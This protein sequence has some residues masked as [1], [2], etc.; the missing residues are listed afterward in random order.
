MWI[1]MEQVHGGDLQSYLQKNVVSEADMVE[2]MR[3]LI[4]GIGY[5]HECG[6]IHRDLKPENILIETN[7]PDSFTIKIT[8]F[9]LSKLGSPAELIFDCCGTPAYVAPEVLHK[10]G[11]K[12]QVDLWACGIILYSMIS[13]TFP[14]QSNDRKQTFLQIKQKEPDFSN[15]AFQEEVSPACIDFIKRLLEKDPA[16]RISVD[17]ALR[18]QFFNNNEVKQQKS[19][20]A[21]NT[22]QFGGVEGDN[23]KFLDYVSNPMLAQQKQAA[24]DNLGILDDKVPEIKP[25]RR[26]IF[27]RRE[28]GDSDQDD[29]NNGIEVVDDFGA[30]QNIHLQ[31]S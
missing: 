23:A 11:Y 26:T 16:K 20:H 3:Q 7:N 28:G 6:I 21:S 29:D 18:H 2:I 1:V 24:Q 22:L 10:T 30:K 13:K 19:A 9:G 15:P 5:L 27:L 14:F 4:R 25:G 12:A 8:D 31:T 17:E